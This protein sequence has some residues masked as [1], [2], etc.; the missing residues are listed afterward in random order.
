M[1]MFSIENKLQFK[2]Q[3]IK[4]YSK[5]K[6]K[7]FFLPFLTIIFVLILFRQYFL[8]MIYF[9]SQVKQF[10]QNFHRELVEDL[11]FNFNEI[12]FPFYVVPNIVH[13]ILFDVKNIT[14][15]H[16][17]SLLSVMKNQKPD[18]IYIHCNCHQLSGDY[19]E[20]AL[21]VAYKTNTQLI[22][23]TIERPTQIYGQKL[24]EKYLNWHSFDISRLQVL[25]EFGGIYLDRDV[26][27]VQSLD[28]FRKYEM[29]LEW[30]QNQNLENSLMIANKN[31]R[32]PRIWLD[33]YHDYDPNQYSFNAGELPTEM[34]LKRQPHLVNRVM[35][36]FGSSFRKTGV[37]PL[38]YS[39]YYENW[40]KDFYAFH[41]HIRDNE[42]SA[43]RECFE[44]RHQNITT[45]F[46]EENVKQLNVTFGQMSRIVFDFEK[47]IIDKK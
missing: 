40:M 32:F 33:S 36:K 15:G 44:G 16:F 19:Y 27:V 41:L 30:N 17:V 35:G 38:L 43:E 2:Q 31:A 25:M 1:K 23:R 8:Q 45:V 24:S 46:T 42:M 37:C 7:K 28:V 9:Q 5:L 14:F 29:T 3:F 10:D 20:R 21:R 47:Q 18:L 34:I 13:Y 6:S 39:S 4:M 11:Y 26:Y 12:G 22:V